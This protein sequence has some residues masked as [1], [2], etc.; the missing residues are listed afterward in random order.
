MTI[1]YRSVFDRQM[2]EDVGAQ[3]AFDDKLLD[4]RV[5]FFSMIPNYQLKEF[6]ANAV[7]NGHVSTERSVHD[8]FTTTDNEII[9]TIEWANLESCQ[10][11]VQL[12]KNNPNLGFKHAE[13]VVI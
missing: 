9:V 1:L 2:L 3:T 8:S 4:N 10:Q 11:V 6:M 13:C 12:K 7:N 5:A